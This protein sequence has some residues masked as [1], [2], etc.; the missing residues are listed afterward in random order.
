MKTLKEKR[1]ELIRM[2]DKGEIT[3]EG[4]FDEIFK[5]D[6]QAIKDF[7]KALEDNYDRYEG[8]YLTS[9]RELIDK[10][11]GDLEQKG[12]DEK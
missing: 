10:I 12:S 7:K 5:Q 1:I 11:F 2:W 9:P 8:Y 6:A 4:V 3:I